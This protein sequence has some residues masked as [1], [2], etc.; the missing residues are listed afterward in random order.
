MPTALT[1]FSGA[2]GMC[3]GLA[4]AGFE[5]IGGN[6]WDPLIAD[7]WDANHPGLKC[8]RRSILDIPIEDLPYADLYHFSPPCQ[9]HSQ[10]NPNRTTGTDD[11]D[12]AIAKK[13]A[14]IIIYGRDPQWITLENV[15]AYQKS[16]SWRIILTALSIAGYSVDAK[17]INAYDYGNPQGRKRFIVRAGLQGVEPLV[18]NGEKTSWDDVLL[19]ALLSSTRFTSLSKGQAKEFKLTQPSAGF[20][21]AQ[22]TGYSVKNGP[23]IIGVNKPCFTITAAMA[24]DGKK[25]KDGLPSFRSPATIVVVGD[26]WMA[27]EIRAR[28]L[29]ALQGFPDDWVWPGAESTAAKAIGNA[30]P[31]QLAKAIG[32]SLLA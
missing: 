19:C 15:P 5:I 6:E 8:D 27:Y 22:R 28:G 24:H 17:V 11:E 14:N 1:F 3:A 31:V 32:L 9:M 18:S 20:Y 21:L 7:I 16:K 4:Q 25:N 26:P 13:I 29:A 2:G 30:V 10:G 23:Q 12:T